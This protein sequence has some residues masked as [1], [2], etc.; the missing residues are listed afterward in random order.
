MIKKFLSLYKAQK[1][2][3]RV[4]NMKFYLSFISLI[5][6]INK[7]KRIDEISVKIVMKYHESHDYDFLIW[8]FFV[9]NLLRALRRIASKSLRI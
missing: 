1:I 2:K 8:E 5:N 3:L 4:L 6:S 7:N 9:W